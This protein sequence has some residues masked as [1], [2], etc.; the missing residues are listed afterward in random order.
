MELKRVSLPFEIKEV[1]EDGTF[2]GVASVYGVEDLG[3]DV[4]EK[5]ALRKTIAENPNVPVLWQHDMTEV[6]GMGE[7][8]E[9][10]NKILLTGSLDLEDGMAMKAYRKLKNGLIKGLSIGYQTVKATYEEIEESG[11]TR[12][13]RHVQEL[14]LWEVSIVTFPMLPAA[15]VTRVKSAEERQ[16]E[17]R[18]VA[19]EEDL[20]ALQATKATPPAE[21][22]KA[23]EPPPAVTPEPDRGS[24]RLVVRIDQMR[25]LIAERRL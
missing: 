13:V 5:G 1:K 4:I 15:Q 11:R 23:E 18:I 16:L 8:K 9:W 19:L 14:K 2:S 25:K 24:L 12:F 3:G 17:G 20:R 21:P 22:A 6:I 10:Q 7:V